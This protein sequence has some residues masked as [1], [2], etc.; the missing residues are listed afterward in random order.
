MAAYEEVF[1][2]EPHDY[3]I[4]EIEELKRSV[5]A[6]K[7]EKQLLES[8][9]DE[10]DKQIAR[11]FEDNLNLR[12]CR[13]KVEQVLHLQSTLEVRNRSL[14]GTRPSL[15][16]SGSRE[17]RAAVSGPR[18]KKTD[19]R[20]RTRSPSREHEAKASRQGGEEEPGPREEEG[21]R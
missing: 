18:D 14:A 7:K 15:T 12:H 5:Q 9:I 11:L 17:P 20:V 1:E 8:E 21:A 2:S 16:E 19:R 6:V 13:E 3:L 4:K 10:K